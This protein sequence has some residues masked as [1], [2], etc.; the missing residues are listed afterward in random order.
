[1]QCYATWIIWQYWNPQ[2]RYCVIELSSK[3]LFCFIILFFGL[4]CGGECVGEQIIC[5]KSQLHSNY[6]KKNLT[7]CE[8][9][10][11]FKLQNKNCKPH[12]WKSVHFV[13]LF[14]DDAKMNSSKE[15]AIWILSEC[16][17]CF[18]S[19]AKNEFFREKRSV[20]FN[21]V[22][23]FLSPVMQRMNFS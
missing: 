4:S 5:F 1:M 2:A 20:L 16:F 6:W 23:P 17:F 10:F 9:Y 15:C 7:W 19:Y 3:F 18:Y 8:I 22:F 12:I 13:F 21:C 14:S 11:F